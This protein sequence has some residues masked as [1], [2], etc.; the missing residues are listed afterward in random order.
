MTSLM[1]HPLSE[2][3]KKIET[4]HRWIRRK[5]LAVTAQ[6]AVKKGLVASW[7]NRNIQHLSKN[8]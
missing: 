7:E 6:P 8:I 3:T 2:F 4:V 5:K 1:M